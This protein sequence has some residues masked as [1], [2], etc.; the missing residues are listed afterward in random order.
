MRKLL[1]EIATLELTIHLAD[2]S[3]T[4]TTPSISSLE[5]HGQS[6][7]AAEIDRLLFSVH[8][9]ISSGNDRHL[10]GNSCLT[11]GH[12]VA[13]LLDNLWGRTDESHPSVDYGLGKVM[14]LGQESIS[15]V[16]GIN[17]V[18]FA[19]SNDLGNAQ[20]GIDRWQS[21]SHNVRL[22]GLLSVH[23]HLIL[24]RVDGHRLDAQ[25]IASAEDPNGD[26]S[27]VSHQHGADWLVLDFRGIRVLVECRRPETE[28]GLLQS[29]KSISYTA[30]RHLWLCCE[31]AMERECNDVLRPVCPLH[32]IFGDTIYKNVYVDIVCVHKNDIHERS[33]AE[34]G[35]NG[36]IKIQLSNQC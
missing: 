1:L 35:V 25:L 32:S 21:L 36:P 27:A 6:M 30:E 28:L 22:V 7:T 3:H 12:L 11:G 20:V 34:L 18:L 2:D 19:H 16:D 24:L 5:D 15:R 31:S 9:T 14:T 33:S 4:A 13:H 26:L 29:A 10:S 23:V 8:G 17:V